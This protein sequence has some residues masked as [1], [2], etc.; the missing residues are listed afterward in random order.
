MSLRS[1]VR[2]L[3][4]FCG[5]VIVGTQ[6]GTFGAFAQA[7]AT[8]AATA[9][10][11]ESVNTKADAAALAGH[12][13]W[14]LT[15]SALVLFM[16]AP[17]LA[18]FYG[19]LVRKKNI[20]SVM[21]QCLFLMGLM[22]VIWALY[23]YSLAFGDP[24]SAALKPYIG[25]GDYLFMKGVART[26]PEGA[27]APV[28][29][30]LIGAI[31]RATHML[32]QGMFFI[33]TPG[34]ICGAFAERMKFC[35]MVWFSILWGT[36]VYCPLCHWV[37]GG[38]MLSYTPAAGVTPLLG[39]ALDFAGGTVVHIS[40]GVS[41]LICALLIGRRIGFGQEDM[42]P[43]NLTY[44]AL[45]AAM[46]WVGWFGF[47]AG[48]ELASDT[49]TSSAF[50]TTHFAAAAGAIAWA[51]YDWITRGKP[52]VLGT[53]SGLVAGL[54][55]ITP[56]AGFVN[57]MPALLIGALAGILCAFA[58]SKMKAKFGYDDALDAFGVHGVGGTL[59][60]VLTGVFATR[61]CWDIGAVNGAAGTKLGL[62]EGG[63]VL[64]G[65]VAAVV[66]TWVFSIVVTFLIL[67]VLDAVMGL[68]VSPQD[69][70]LGLDVSQH[71]EEG[72]IFV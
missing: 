8:P 60:A 19:G 38:G 35:T 2:S 7:P 71:E 22:T 65:Q 49:L 12:N 14:M 53:A 63:K 15:S 30:P 17:G 61:A 70:S 72:Y 64:G 16:T 54:V 68:R 50:A 46:L 13:A 43:H 11:L 20:L 24:E 42:R 39:G 55:C 48:S 26:W 45:G 51:C 66:V 28:D 57:L 25:G 3:A 41:A 44:T 9:V 62:L 29:P 18:M 6:A 4:I 34:L 36:F 33:I 37:W 1:C 40:S 52:T 23:G 56:G 31:P 67:K 10:T 32:F 5:A 58:S 21:M 47:N 59:G 69:E 27:T